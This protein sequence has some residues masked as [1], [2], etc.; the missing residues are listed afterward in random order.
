VVG[1][2]LNLPQFRASKNP[3]GVLAYPSEVVAAAYGGERWPA[4]PFRQSAG[5]DGFPLFLQQ[6]MS[7]PFMAGYMGV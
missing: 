7:R 6:A 2:V 4:P 5:V 1:F 3:H